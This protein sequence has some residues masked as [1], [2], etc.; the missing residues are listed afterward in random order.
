MKDSTFWKKQHANFIKQKLWPRRC[1]YMESARRIDDEIEDLIDMEIPDNELERYFL[2]LIFNDALNQA[3]PIGIY[4][5]VIYEYDTYAWELVALFERCDEV[6]FHKQL[7]VCLEG[8][9]NR[10]G[11]SSRNQIYQTELRIQLEITQLN[12]IKK[13]REKRTK[14]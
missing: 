8:F 6:E 13:A 11:L 7:P 14:Q 3:D 9:W 4:P 1:A 2:F 12:K 10:M 5:D